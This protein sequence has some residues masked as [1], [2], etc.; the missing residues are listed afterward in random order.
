MSN[1]RKEYQKQYR[2]KNKERMKEINRL[3]YLK[4]KKAKEQQKDKAPMKHLLIMLS[5]NKQKRLNNMTPNRYERRE[6]TQRA[7]YSELEVV[8]C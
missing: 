8:R 7:I 2:E 1:S 4:R 3:N 5:D 6:R